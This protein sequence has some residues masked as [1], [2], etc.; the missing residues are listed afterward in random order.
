MGESLK[1]A[2]RTIGEGTVQESKTIK[3]ETKQASKTIG[4]GTEHSLKQI[5]SLAWTVGTAMGT[6]ALLILILD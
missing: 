6:S 3:E 1:Q 5:E 2:G 4:E